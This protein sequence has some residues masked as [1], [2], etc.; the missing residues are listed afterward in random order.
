MLNALGWTCPGE[1]RLSD[2]TPQRRSVSPPVSL[3]LHISP[4][5]LAQVGRTEDDDLKAVRPGLVPS[6]CTRRDAHDVQLPDVDDLVIE[7]HP[8]APVNDHED[9]L[10]L[11]VR[12]AIREAIVRRDPLIA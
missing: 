4:R 7:L 6:P 12:V 2:P 5:V 9:L 10:L 11:L 3:T 1:P 8:S